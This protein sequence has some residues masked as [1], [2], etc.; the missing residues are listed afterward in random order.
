MLTIH[1]QGGLSE[2]FPARALPY[3]EQALPY[4]KAEFRL[5]RYIDDVCANSDAHIAEL[6]DAIERLR[7]T[8]QHFTAVAI[9]F[10]TLGANGGLPQGVGRVR[11]MEEADSAE[12]YAAACGRPPIAEAACA[13]GGGP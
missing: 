3:W 11:A 6:N 2:R 7:Q 13:E 5:Y 9:E 8:T 4:T 10:G 1:P 12:P